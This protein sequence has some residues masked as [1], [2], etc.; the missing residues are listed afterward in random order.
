MKPSEKLNQ[1]HY[2]E[3]VKGKYE[4]TEK[5]FPAGTY[6]VR[7]NQSLGNLAVYLLEPQADDG[8]L[9]WNFFDRYLEPQ[10]GGGYF[11]YPVYRLEEEDT[12]KT[13]INNQK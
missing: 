2:T 3:K 13:T 6:V 1:G 5:V 11:P 8:L 12:L 4:E 7:T 10:W 9:Y